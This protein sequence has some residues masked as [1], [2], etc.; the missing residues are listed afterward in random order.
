[1]ADLN[2]LFQN[3]GPTGGAIMSGLTTGQDLASSFLQDQY[4]QVQMNKAQQEMDQAAIMN[5][6]LIQSKQQEISSA[7]LKAKQDRQSY[8]NDVVGNLIPELQNTPA[9]ARHALMEQR[10]REA[11]LPL[12]QADR[13]WAQTHN[14][15]ELLKKL[16]SAHE[17]QITQ[18]AK[19]RTE[20]DKAALHNQG[21]L[22][23]EN[24]REAAKAKAAKEKASAEKSLQQ[25]L[26]GAKTYQAQAVVYSNHAAKARLKGDTEEATRLETLAKQA[27]AQDL[28]ARAAA[29]DAQA[30]RQL[31]LLQGLG[32]PLHGQPAAPGGAPSLPAGWT[33]K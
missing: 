18:S 30:Q 2:S 26:S 8:Y 33:V 7:E 31:Q 25:D 29:G 11:G 1:M 13:D 19:Y 32:V 10:L 15:D 22:D 14:G 20:M 21:L 27:N 28:A 23:V 16:K 12:D 3:L 9:P 17:W 4:R 24:A 6:L 5:P